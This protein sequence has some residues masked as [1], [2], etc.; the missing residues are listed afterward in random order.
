M[1]AR[2]TYHK[3]LDGI[4][5]TWAATEVPVD[6]DKPM[7]WDEILENPWIYRMVQTNSSAAVVVD[8]R[9]DV[10]RIQCGHVVRVLPE[11]GRKWTFYPAKDEA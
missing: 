10:Y 8:S 4:D 7:S 9:K 1:D 3:M 11:E 2:A 6:R 5:A